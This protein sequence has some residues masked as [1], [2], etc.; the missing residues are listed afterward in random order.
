M[1]E[2]NVL[3]NITNIEI[4]D[5]EPQKNVFLKVN[6][7]NL[8]QLLEISS[9]DI[10]QF[11]DQE[12][13]DYA[14]THG[15]KN[16]LLIAEEI[17]K[18]LKTPPFKNFK[19]LIAS[20]TP[21]I[22]G[23]D[24]ELKTFFQLNTVGQIDEK[25]NINFKEKNF[26]IGV[27]T[28][29]LIA[30]YI[31]PTKGIDG[32]DVFG[33]IL[34]AQDGKEIQLNTVKIDTADIDRVEDDISIKFIAKKKGSLIQKNGIFHIEEN[35]KIDK[36]DIKTGNIYLKD[37][38]DVNIG[39][40][41]VIE[42]D[43]I[44]PGIKVTGKKV[45]VNGNVGSNAYVEADIVD[46]KGSVH[47]NAIIK[48]KTAC[49]KNLNG[50][51]IAQEAFIEHANYANIEANSKVTI[52]NCLACRIVSPFVEI[53][54]RVFNQNIIISSKE[55]ILN[56]VT[57]INNKISIKP[58]EIKEISEQYEQLILEEKE[59]FAKIQ[60]AKSMIG[61][62]KKKFDS[63]LENY[64]RL[65]KLIKERRSKNLKIPKSLLDS[66]KRI[67]EMHDDYQE[68]MEIVEM[69]DKNYKEIAYRLKALSQSYKNARI[70][71]NGEIESE[72]I[73][74]FSDTLSK[75]LTNKLKRI[76]IYVNEIDNNEE[77]A[78]DDN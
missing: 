32:Y 13:K 69:L 15:I 57:G 11:I 77:I 61:M 59:F 53:K 46:I 30:E 18:R 73:I 21:P 44:G 8:D 3:E 2:E 29:T 6:C 9:S 51:L 12:L 78:I 7:T 63:N 48:A 5:S 65:I 39:V 67:E 25:G 42:E 66:L 72:N 45:V 64:N 36:A 34:K 33:N 49:I 68:Q 50:T 54:K 16:L 47:K 43:T 17:Q 37:V 40:R 41:N 10:V 26:A 71:V 60:E 23:N 38:S 1:E 56:D 62:L 55:I 70:L 75:V 58:F 35:V 14:I 19:V 76:K 74:E 22:N 31:K 52:D 27:N 20:G 4:D 24:F 28:G